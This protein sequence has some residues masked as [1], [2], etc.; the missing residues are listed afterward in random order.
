M[1]GTIRRYPGAKPFSVDQRGIF[2]GRDQDVEELAELISIEQSVVLYS[3]SGY[4]KSSLINAGVIPRL[5]KEDNLI[6]FS[7]RFGAYTKGI[8]DS[9]LAITIDRLSF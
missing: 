3:K 5:E 4:G 6:P 9:P 7:F 1:G 2:F 8:A